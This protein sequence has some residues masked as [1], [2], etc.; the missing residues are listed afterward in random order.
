MAVFV[1]G[2]DESS[3]R[4]R[5]DPFFFG[6]F[7]G[8]EE[9]W[10]RFFA[11]AWQERVL[12]G[13]PAIPYLHMTDIRSRAWR[14]KYGISK[15]Q[16]DDRIDEAVILL[17]AMANLYPIGI[18]VDA[19][20]LGDTFS[21]IRVTPRTGGAGR[22]DP[23]Y[24]C[25]LAYTYI[26]LSHVARNH[27]DAEKVDFVIERNGHVT[28]YIQEFHFSLAQCL[29]Q[30]GRPDLAGLVGDLIPGGKERVPLQAADVLCWHASRPIET[31]DSND[32][33]RFAK[34]ARRDGCRVEIT[35]EEIS[36]IEAGVLWK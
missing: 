26:V 12:D 30:L 18:H 24:I 5:R 27:P 29:K 2:S 14:D 15:L 1:S 6:G 31:M 28:R 16:A 7:V 22:F 3:G 20:H 13:P 25:F 23:D 21:N 17:D 11:P 10:S 9:D 8:P 33:K 36:Q 35:K 19:G 4:N 32:I 34:L